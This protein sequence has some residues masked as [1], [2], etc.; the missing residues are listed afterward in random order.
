MSDNPK[1]VEKRLKEIFI[2]DDVLF[3]VFSFCDPVLLGLKVALISDRFDRLVD[4]HFKLNGLSLT[5]FKIYRV[6]KWNVAKISNRVDCKERRLPIPQEPL[7]DNVIGFQGFMISYIDRSVIDFLKRIR[8]LFDSNGINLIIS[9][10]YNYKQTRSWEIIWQK[11]WPLINDNISGMCLSSCDL[12][13]LRKFSPTVLGDCAKLRTF[14]YLALVPAFPSDDSAGAS[15]GQAVA[16]WLHTPRGDGLPKVLH[17]GFCLTAVEGLKREFVNSTDPLNFIILWYCCFVGDV[18]VPFEVKNNLTGERL[19]L[20]CLSRWKSLLVRCPIERDD[21]KWAEL[22]KEA[23]EWEWRRHQLNRISILLKDRGGIGDDLFDANEGPNRDVKFWRCEQFGTKDV[24][25]KARLHTDLNNTVKKSLNQHICDQSA[26][27]VEAQ[28]IKTGIKR[29]AEVTM[30]TPSVIRA[31]AIQNIPTPVLAELSNKEALRKIVQR[32]RI[33]P[34]RPPPAPSNI[35]DLQIPDTHRFYKRSDDQLEEQFLLEDSGVYSEQ[36]RQNRWARQ[37]EHI[38][39]DGTFSIAPTMFSQVF[40]VLARRE[41]WVF[42][43]L[44][45][46]LTSKSKETYTKFFQMVRQSWPEF[47]PRSASTDYEAAIIGAIND[48]YQT[49]PLLAMRAKMVTSMAFLP[50]GDLTPGIWALERELPAELQPILEWFIANYTGRPRLDGVRSQPKFDP[51]IWNVHQR[52]VQGLDRTNNFCESAH[53]R[54]Q[55]LFGCDHPSVWRFDLLRMAQKNTDAEFS[56]F[57]AGHQ[58]AK[59]R[60]KFREA[61]RRIL[62]LIQRYTPVNPAHNDH[63]YAANPNHQAIIEFLQGISYNYNMNP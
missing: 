62:E 3:G 59:K 51:A 28:R 60:Q 1:K 4:A 54:L 17:C 50:I 34:N 30:E 36:G 38:Y 46:L 29:R 12:A 42:P 8:R 9:T 16:K 31:L 32:V 13:C 18:P 25:C 27:H 2:C 35:A 11:I 53:R 63:Q 10:D 41:D 57:I 40:V 47:N 20:R 26:A 7:P 22:E 58:A 61:D 44:Y 52:T 39:V 49:D 15:S 5:F 19:V 43:V 56:Q 14:Q 48:R 55:R 23:I 37:M 24:M 21:V 6:I 45:G 33:S